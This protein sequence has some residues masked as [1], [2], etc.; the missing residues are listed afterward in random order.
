MRACLTR[1]FAR[2]RHTAE[3]PEVACQRS[4][5]YTSLQKALWGGRARARLK[6][7]PPF[8]VSFTSQH[9]KPVSLDA[10]LGAVLVGCSVG[11]TPSRPR[12]A[13]PDQ[14]HLLGRA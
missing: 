3:A 8:A 9:I 4:T 10:P 6:S 1:E 11:K 12:R 5:R 7:D 2:D 14:V 13:V